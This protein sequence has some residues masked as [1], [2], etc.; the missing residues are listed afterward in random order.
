M[1]H[2]TA[3]IDR[4]ATE[5]TTG[6]RASVTL[7]IV[8]AL[9]WL[10]VYFPVLQG[11]AADWWSNP[12]YS[13]GLLVPFAIAAILYHRRAVLRA[14]PVQPSTAVG[15]L[16]IG[17]SQAMFLVGYLGAEFFLQRSAMVG[18]AVGAI[19][20]LAG[21]A[22]LKPLLLPLLLFQLSIPIPAIVFN[23]IA[24]PLQLL[25]S[26][27]AETIL[28]VCGIAV[29]RSGNI[30]QLSRQTMNVT[31]ACSGI[32][33]LV[34]L[35]TLAVIMIAFDRVHW[36]VRILFVGSAVVVAV[37]ANAI[38]VSGTGLLGYFFG[39][40]AA[41]GFFHLFEGWFIFVLSFVL[42]GLELKIIKRLFT[43]KPE[44]ASA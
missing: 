13:H 5:V 21:W 15:M 30:L 8:L 41:T 26:C 27:W 38:R 18:L 4:I 42:L 10:L 20:F 39:M 36:L 3:V 37:V 17:L 12:D 23:R 14:A 32:R 7:W 31:E 25:A 16:A 1:A 40:R 44:G 34:S 9:A 35:I 24:L 11:L 19:L 33:S 6:K 28:R 2:G 22:W 29:Y 43:Q